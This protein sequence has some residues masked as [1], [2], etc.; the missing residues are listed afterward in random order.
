M[1]ITFK[2]VIMVSVILALAFMGGVAA[3]MMSVVLPKIRS[4]P[5]PA[6]PTPEQLPI[7]EMENAGPPIL[8][9]QTTEVLTKT[10]E[11]LDQ[12]RKDLTQQQQLQLE[13]DQD[14]L[15]REELIKNERAALHVERE[16][17]TEIQARIEENLKKHR[18]EIDSRLLTVNSEEDANLQKMA[19]LYSQMKIEQ[20]VELLRG[21]PD[22][23]IAKILNLSTVKRQAKIIDSWASKYPDDRDRILRITELLKKLGAVASKK[24]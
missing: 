22:E 21:T 10:A 13:K 17:L 7:P 11:E 2:T 3:V 16:R 6:P 4:I 18:N 20:S 12:W 15:R 8:R 19:E 24:E 14:L 5:Q 1:K 23:Q 9:P